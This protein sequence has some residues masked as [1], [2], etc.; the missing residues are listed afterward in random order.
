MKR[1][2]LV[3]PAT[4][5]CSPEGQAIADGLVWSYTRVAWAIIAVLA[6]AVISGAIVG[7]RKRRIV[8]QVAWHLL[9]GVVVLIVGAAAGMVAFQIRESLRIAEG[10]REIAITRAWMAPLANPPAGVLEFADRWCARALGAC[11]T[12]LA[13]AHLAAAEAL[14]AAD[15]YAAGRLK[16]IRSRLQTAPQPAAG[17]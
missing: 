10:E 9:W 4:V 15:P 12:A 8:R 13:P 3:S 6:V 16:S 11:R 17:R 14:V 5:A 2:L 7:Y 1:S